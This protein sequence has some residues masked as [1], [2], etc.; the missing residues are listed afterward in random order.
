MRRHAPQG[1]ERDAQAPKRHGAQRGGHARSGLGIEAAVDHE[2]RRKA[3]DL[4]G[5]QRQ[6]QRLVV[7]HGAQELLDGARVLLVA[8]LGAGVHELPEAGVAL[9]G[10]G[11]VGHEKS[12]Q[13]AL[14]GGLE[15]RGGLV[16]VGGVVG[17]GADGRGGLAPLRA[18]AAH[19]LEG[20]GRVAVDLGRHQAARG[21]L[22]HIEH[23]QVANERTRRRHGRQ[24]ALGGRVRHRGQHERPHVV[25]GGER[26]PLGRSREA[27]PSSMVMPRSFSSLRRSVSMPVKAFTRLVFP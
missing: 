26:Q 16:A 14:Q 25:G 10:K 13:P 23:L 18:V 3:Q 2:K 9:G 8:R 5:D 20:H 22:G 17:A 21:V 27:N 7:P 4:V 15:V 6:A 24:A 1:I 19:A 12:P 11:R